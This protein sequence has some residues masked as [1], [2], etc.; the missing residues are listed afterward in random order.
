MVTRSPISH[1][2]V[3]DPRIVDIVDFGPN[4]LSFVGLEQG[5]TTVTLWFGEAEVPLILQVEVT[6][7]LGV[8]RAARSPDVAIRAI[9]RPD[10]TRLS[11]ASGPTVG[12]AP[13][14]PEPSPESQLPAAANAQRRPATA[15]PIPRYDGHTPWQVTQRRDAQSAVPALYEGKRQAWR[16]ADDRR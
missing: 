3:A 2:F 10:R 7:S 1:T 5:A 8:A 11:A 14:A 4:E 16:P 9:P 15:A 12:H 13:F 6:P